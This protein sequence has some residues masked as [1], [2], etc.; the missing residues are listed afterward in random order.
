MRLITSPIDLKKNIP[1]TQGFGKE[2]TLLQMVGMYK[3]L[4]LKDG[5][6]NGIDFGTTFGTDLFACFDGMVSNEIIY[7]YTE[8]EL[9]NH[10]EYIPLMITRIINKEKGLKA[11]YLHLSEFIVK[12]GEKVKEGELLCKSGNSGRWTTGSHTHFD[13]Y[14]IDN[15]GNVLNTNNG[16]FGAIDPLPFIVEKLSD[17]DLI[18]NPSD[19]PV[20]Y[21]KNGQ[22]WWIKDEKVFE[23]WSGLKVNLAD[24]KIVDLLTYNY[25]K[26][27]GFIINL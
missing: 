24:I 15:N 19:P 22:K 18:K 26:T 8:S 2:G 21:I 12:N 6:H 20:Y 17:G 9:E 16:L 7:E 5:Q 10:P 13:I 4:G 3:Q 23:K 1:M 25:Y 11:R 14:E 27:S